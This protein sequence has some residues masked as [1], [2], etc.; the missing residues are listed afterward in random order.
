MWHSHMLETKT[1]TPWEIN[2]IQGLF[3]GLYTFLNPT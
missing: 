1:I 2:K 3:L